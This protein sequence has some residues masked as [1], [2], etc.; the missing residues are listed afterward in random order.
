MKLLIIK[1]SSLGDV[2]HGFAVAN[3][4][5]KQVKGITIDWLVGDVYAELVEKHPA[6]RKVW[7]FRRSAWGDNWQNRS[8]WSEIAS[9]ITSIRSEKYDVCLDLQGLLRSGLITLLSGAPK[10]VGYLNGREGSKYCYNVRLENGESE[11]AVDILLQSLLFFDAKTPES[12]TFK[13]DIPQKAEIGVK[14]LLSEFGVSDR[15]IVFHPGARWET[16]KWPVEKWSE[17]ADSISKSALPGLRGLP[18]LGGLGGL[19]I[20]F[21]GSDSESG[22]VKDI[23]NGRKNRFSA[24]G[25]LT[26]LE[27]AALL[28]DAAAMV[29]VDSGPMHVA[30]T[31]GTPIVAL[32]GATSIAKT[33]PRSS[34]SVKL[35]TA[36]FDCA[37]CFKRSCDIKPN[38]MDA[39]TAAEVET[40]IIQLLG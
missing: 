28:K 29:T 24:A 8:T 25:R 40:Q 10:R 32:F 5:R 30:A 9:F 4:L 12:V 34:G 27:L 1:I 17:L 3:E 26:L 11:H 18:G 31:F 37:P 21:T 39:I 20:I 2:I 33:S 15:Y 22:M 38:C 13:F 7:P 14:K 35:V 23:I 19:P 36:S 16:K 6:V